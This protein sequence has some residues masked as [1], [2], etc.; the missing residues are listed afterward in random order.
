MDD[1]PLDDS[2]CWGFALFDAAG[3]LLSLCGLTSKVCARLGL[4]PSKSIA[5]ETT[6]R[7]DKGLLPLNTGTIGIS[8]ALATLRCHSDGKRMLR[9][10]YW[11]AMPEVTR[12][13]PANP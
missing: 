13:T 4:I 9:T 12:K 2:P 3:F 5:A 1:S 7:S 8:D 10:S 6:T 11:T